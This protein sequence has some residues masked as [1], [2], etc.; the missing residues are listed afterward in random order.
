[1]GLLLDRRCIYSDAL[2]VALGAQPY[3]RTRVSNPGSLLGVWWTT[4]ITVMRGERASGPVGAGL[5]QT[6]GLGH[7]PTLSYR[8]FCTLRIDYQL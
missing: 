1:M 4:W 8:L 5:F 6:L 3:L 2:Q 7:N